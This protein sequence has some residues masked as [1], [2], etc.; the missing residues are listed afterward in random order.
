MLKHIFT[1]NIDLVRKQERVE[2]ELELHKA[3]QALHYASAMIGYY[4]RRLEE[5]D[6]I[7]KTC[8]TSK[9]IGSVQP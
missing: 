8:D 3:Q 4:S 9:P 2:A 5:L 1:P 7:S 6:K